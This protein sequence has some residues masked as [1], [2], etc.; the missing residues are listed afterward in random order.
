MSKFL[1][2]LTEARKN[3]R[4]RMA[5]VNAESSRRAR[6]RAKQRRGS[7]NKQ[8]YYKNGEQR[9]VYM[10]DEAQPLDETANL[11]LARKKLM[12][13]VKI[14]RALS[15]HHEKLATHHDKETEKH[16][17]DK[18]NKKYDYHESK[19]IHHDTLSNLHSSI[20]DAHEQAAD[21]MRPY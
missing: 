21:D 2:Y 6:E 4:S 3:P 12:A 15:K 19:M 1:D 14:H 17:N 13:K 5:A 8:G 10:K 20:A 18:G 11:S 7:G 9:G 16:A